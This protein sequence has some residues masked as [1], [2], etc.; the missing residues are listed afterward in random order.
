LQTDPAPQT[1]PHPP[2]LPTSLEMQPPPQQKPTS[3][4]LVPG[5]TQIWLSLFAAQVSRAQGPSVSP[6][7]V[8]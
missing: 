6:K 7:L 1:I 4:S 5:S 2:Q 8:G 3:S